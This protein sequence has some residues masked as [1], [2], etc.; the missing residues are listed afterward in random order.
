MRLGVRL[1][2]DRIQCVF[3]IAVDDLVVIVGVDEPFVVCLH[4]DR[5]AILQGGDVG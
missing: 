4:D 1:E 2:W 3:L 5:V